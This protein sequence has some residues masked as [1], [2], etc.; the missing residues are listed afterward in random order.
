M[1]KDDNG[2][3]EKTQ[4]MVRVAAGASMARSIVAMFDSATVKG[5]VKSVVK[6]FYDPT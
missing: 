4:K 5:L 3:Q 2:G 6:W 1:K